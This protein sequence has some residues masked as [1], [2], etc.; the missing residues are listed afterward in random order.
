MD[1][2][3]FEEII[4]EKDGETGIV[5]V[6]LNNPHIKNAMT[7]GMFFELSQAV[8]AMQ[9]DE[10]VR[11]MILTGAKPP[12]T[13]DPSK[14]AF[15]SGGYFN[16]AYMEQLD[17]EKKKQIDIT[18]VAQ[19]KFTLKMWEF[20]KP[21]IAAINGMAIGGGI[22]LPLSCADLIFMSEHAWAR[23]PFVRLGVCPELASSYILPRIIGLQRAKEIMFF[24]EDLSAQTL[25]DMG[26][27]N[28]VLPHDQLL[29]H[30]REIACRLIPPD[31]AFMSVRLTKQAMNRPLIQAVTES[32]DREN[33]FLLQTFS[34]TDF[35]EAIM[36]RREKRLP[37]FK[38]E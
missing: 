14:E 22:T 9:A 18:D 2:T 1:V 7:L 8:D 28:K 4:Y 27:I 20:D 24:G 13:D 12:D 25:F 19:K 16:P 31:G 30:A 29:S 17:A 38:G 32:L 35:F 6:T 10:G 34:T 11:A 15:S 3:S 26:I 21:V 37:V 33:E 23:F 36:A 5:T